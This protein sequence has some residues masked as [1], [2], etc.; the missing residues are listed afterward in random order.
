M[1][2][3]VLRLLI[4]FAV[5]AAIY[6]ALVAYMRWDRRKTLEEEHAAGAGGSLTREDYVSKGLARYERS[7]ERKLLYGV[8]A[9]PVVVGM[10]LIVL[11]QLS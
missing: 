1:F 9:I 2:L 7:W 5:L 10:I 3:V 11:A 8:F 6:V 4:V